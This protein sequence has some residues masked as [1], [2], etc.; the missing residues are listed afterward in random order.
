[1]QKGRRAEDR[2]GA[3]GL[4]GLDRDELRELVQPGAEDVSPEY[5]KQVEAYLKLIS[6]GQEAL[7]SPAAEPA[8]SP[9]PEGE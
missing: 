4:E 7:D 8:P 3:A 1:M 9:A 2:V 5:R 6:Q